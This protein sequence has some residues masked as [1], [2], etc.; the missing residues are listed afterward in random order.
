M[1]QR[2]SLLFSKHLQETLPR[3]T[4]YKNVKICILLF[5]PS[6][7][8]YSFRSLFVIPEIRVCF[9]TLACVRL[10]VCVSYVE[11]CLRERYCSEPS[12]HRCVSM[13]RSNVFAIVYYVPVNGYRSHTRSCQH[14]RKNSPCCFGSREREEGRWEGGRTG[15]GRKVVGRIARTRRPQMSPLKAP[16]RFCSSSMGRNSLPPSSRAKRDLAGVLEQGPSRLI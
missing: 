9:Y 7:R 1:L 15:E 14:E 11:I 10:C 12:T 5:T 8:S 4:S 13:N 6:P 16:S 2:F 3:N